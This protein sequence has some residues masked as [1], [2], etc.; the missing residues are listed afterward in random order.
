[1]GSAFGC[2]GQLLADLRD[3]ELNVNRRSGVTRFRV[4][5]HRLKI[6]MGDVELI[7]SGNETGELEAS[8]WTGADVLFTQRDG[9]VR[10]QR[11]SAVHD[12]TS[13]GCGRCGDCQSE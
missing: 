3:V 13:D 9:G 2:N 4:H 7:R 8:L 6:V 5:S 11:S 1:M 10:Y 12:N